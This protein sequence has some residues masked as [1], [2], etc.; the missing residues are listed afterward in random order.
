MDALAQ[1]RRALYDER[2][3]Y[4]STRTISN[5]APPM[6]MKMANGLL[7][8]GDGAGCIRVLDLK[9]GQQLQVFQ[10]HKGR[11]TDLFGDRFRVLS[12]SS[13]FSIRVYR[14]LQVDNAAQLESRYTLL[15]GSVVHKEQ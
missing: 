3:M 7:V 11:V 9:S 15:G 1:G 5:T 4:S 8:T 10:D 2:N 14:W 12:C 13:D 6:C